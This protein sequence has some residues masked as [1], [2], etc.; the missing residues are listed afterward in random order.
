MRTAVAKKAQRGAAV[1]RP[2]SWNAPVKGW[3]SNSNIADM[4]KDSAYRLDNW[5]PESNFIRVR[6]GHTEHAQTGTG[7]TVR[8]LM[9]HNAGGTR[10][11]FAA[12]GTRIFD[13]TTTTTLASG[14]NT[15]VT[16]GK[17]VDS[18]ADFSGDGVAVGNVVKNT[19]SGTY[20]YVSAVDSGTALSLSADIFTATPR[21]Y[22]IY[23]TKSVVSSLTSAELIWTNFQTSGGNYL[24]WVN[25]ADSARHYNGS[26]WA[27]PSITGATS[28]TFS[29]T[30]PHKARLFFIKKDTTTVHYLP[31]DAVSG[32][33]GTLDVGGELTLGG[34]LI[35]GAAVTHDSGEGLDDY[36]CFV[37]SEGEV[38]VYS[39][40]DPSDGD[41]WIKKGTFRIGRP[42]G[43]RCLLKIG[44]D[45]AVLTQDGM[46]SLAR[47][48]LL[49]RAAAEKGAFS[50]K[51]SEAFADQYALTGSVFGWQIVTWPTKHMAI[52]NVPITDGE[53]YYQ[54]VMNVLT[55]AWCRFK[56]INS[57]CWVNSGDDLFFGSTDGRVME[58]GTSSADDNTPVD[59]LGIGAFS[60]MGSPGFIKHTKAAQMFTRTNGSFNLGVNMAADFNLV[61]TA[62]ASRA[63]SEQSGALWDDALWDSAVWAQSDAARASWLGVSKSGYFLAPVIVAQAGIG[64]DDPEVAEIEFL[65]M[66]VLYEIGTALG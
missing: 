29:Y 1:A 6:E 48:I 7:S 59:A 31:V 18:G 62:P 44:G 19:T 36:C 9:V 51:I 32:A 38:V 57:Q 43:A 5:F 52:V 56:G 28:S 47:S 61:E 13:A 27:T 3:I 21:N 35:A 37:S 30:F 10:T 22:E 23:S 54:Y 66:N 64:G 34:T 42:I 49:D 39:G 11:L 65:S 60:H 2:A 40:T 16:S 50:N 20:A 12:S 46:V 33:V 25:G 53:T 26:A 45:I 15:S 17:L 55:G 58:Y 41:L 63:F 4:P 24:Y 8:T 14:T